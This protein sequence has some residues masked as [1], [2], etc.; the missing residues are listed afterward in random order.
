MVLTVDLSGDFRFKW[1]LEPQSK[2]MVVMIIL[3]WHLLPVQSLSE[4]QNQSLTSYRTKHFLQ[5]LV[6]TITELKG[7]FL[8]IQ[9]CS[10]A[11][12]CLLH[13]RSC[14]NKK[15]VLS[16]HPKHKELVLMTNSSFHRCTLME[17]K[18][19]GVSLHLSLQN[20]L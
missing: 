3:H 6:E 5:L 17:K 13:F 10:A 1:L 4:I 16:T 18:A 7:C 15:R 14:F 9:N 19:S 8:N 20:T 12:W 11:N 2:M